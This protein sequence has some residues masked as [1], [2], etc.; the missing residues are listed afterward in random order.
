MPGGLT[1]EQEARVVIDHKLEEAGWAVQDH[2]S[3]DLS[4]ASG[5][6]V[7]EFPTA[8]GPADY[9][10]YVDRKALG[11][12][13][14]KKNGV[15]LLGVESQ[16]D[17]YTEGFSLSSKRKPLPRWRLPLPFHYLSTGTEHLFACRLDPDYAPRAVFHFHKPETLVEIA[18]TGKT[19]RQ[20]LRQMPP[21]AAEGLRDNQVAAIRGL[22]ES[23]AHNRLRSLTPQTMGS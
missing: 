8:T 3:I 5:V 11:T 18:K 22:E 13:E 6:A 14:A 7:R 15:P 16:A 1:P 4:A 21:L 19:L 23:F 17:R 9:L 20:R 10:L 12:I 2:R